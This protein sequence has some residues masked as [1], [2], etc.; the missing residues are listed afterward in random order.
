MSSATLARGPGLPRV[1]AHRLRH[2]AATAMRAGA[3][4]AEVG[5]ALRQ[6]RA[7]TTSIYAKVDRVA[8]RPLAQPW[9]GGGA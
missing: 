1:G 6:V 8:L 5:Q 9:P 3:S 2:S 4:L 7:A